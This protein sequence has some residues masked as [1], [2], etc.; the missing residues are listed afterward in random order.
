MVWG[1]DNL[2]EGLYCRVDGNESLSIEAFAV[3]WVII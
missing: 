2:N 1:S 3:A